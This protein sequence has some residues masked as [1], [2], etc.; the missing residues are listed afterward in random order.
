MS[1]RDL[2]PYFMP[3]YVTLGKSMNFLGFVF[4]KRSKKSWLHH[5]SIPFKLLSLNPVNFYS[6]QSCELTYKM[7]FKT[8]VA[9]ISK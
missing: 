8:L 9:V 1:E 3:Y 4:C 5:L 6:W 2:M 7:K